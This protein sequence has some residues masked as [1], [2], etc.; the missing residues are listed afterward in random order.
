MVGT[1]MVR[2][3]SVRRLVEHRRK[4]RL[5]ILSGRIAT[6]VQ[7]ARRRIGGGGG[8]GGGILSHVRHLKLV[9]FRM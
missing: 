7:Q 1:G 9:Q 6:G 3:S 5:V 4:S 8:G 2:S